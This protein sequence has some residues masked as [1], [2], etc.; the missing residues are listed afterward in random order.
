[1]D[2]ERLHSSLA[3]LRA[4]FTAIERATDKVFLL[5]TVRDEGTGRVEISITSQTPTV[6]L[7]ETVQRDLGL[8]E[9]VTTVGAMQKRYGLSQYSLISAG[10]YFWVS[11]AGEPPRILLI[12][13]DAQSPAAGQWTEPAGRCDG[14]PETVLGNEGHEELLILRRRAGESRYRPVVIAGVAY[15]DRS[16][17]ELKRSQFQ[18]KLPQL[19]RLGVHQRDIDFSRAHSAEY[20]ELAHEH[21]LYREVS[22]FGDGSEE[23]RFRA[24]CLFDSANNTLELRR[25]AVIEMDASDSLIAVDGEDFNRDVE[26]F[27]LDEIFGRIANQDFKA[28]P[29]LRLYLSIL[30]SRTRRL[31]TGEQADRTTVGD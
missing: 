11:V 1:M 5:G 26:A 17:L 2:T 14:N 13:R 18:R 3:L 29:A 8:Q 25:S 27:T 20:R 24:I 21:G 9:H 28:R 6:A 16:P 31:Q 15:E 7:D 30:E 4:P 12:K 19:S 10:V 23:R 22:L